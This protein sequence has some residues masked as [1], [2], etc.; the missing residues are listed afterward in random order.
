MFGN[1]RF[2]PTF[3]AT[4][5]TIISVIFMGS[6]SYW[7]LERLAWK[8][9]LIDQFESRVAAE[10]VAAPDK[11][12]NIEDWR[13]RR[14]R[15]QGTYLHDKEFLITGKT[16]EGNVGFHL[17]TPM[18]LVDGRTVLVKRGWIELKH[19]KPADTVPMHVEGIQTVDGLIRQDRLKGYFVPD[20]EPQNDVWLYIDTA[21][22]AEARD[23][24]PVL[25]YFVDQLRARGPLKM[26]TG[27]D[28]EIHV[29]NEHLSYAATWAL[30]ALTLIVIYVIYHMKPEDETEPDRD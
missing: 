5:F 17:V 15:L 30:L 23:L 26:P 8:S 29:R 24:G 25:P 10:P 12:D 19:R 13:Y 14:V 28:S 2:R 4:F 20:N 18:K 7:Q 22:M 16:Y 11:I 27:A 6:L 1:R 9:N 21:E 3:W